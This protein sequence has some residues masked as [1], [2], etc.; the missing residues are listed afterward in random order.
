[1]TWVKCSLFTF[2]RR[3]SRKWQDFWIQF[4]IGLIFRHTYQTFT[5]TLAASCTIGAWNTLHLFWNMLF[6]HYL[7]YAGI[8]RWYYAH[9][10]VV[11][12]C[13][14]RDDH[15]SWLCEVCIITEVNSRFCTLVTHADGVWL[16]MPCCS[17]SWQVEFSFEECLSVGSSTT[18]W[19]FL[20]DYRH[21]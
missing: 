3:P 4:V 14:T 1:M 6:D 21:N 17:F 13:C 18:S 15:P 10:C 11:N 8:V 5:P 9:I 2:Y 16:A 12:I 20:L 7:L 19:V